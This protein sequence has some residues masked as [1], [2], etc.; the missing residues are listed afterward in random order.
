MMILFMQIQNSLFLLPWIIYAKRAMVTRKKKRKRSTR[1]Q[2]NIHNYAQS[3]LSFASVFFLSLSLYLPWLSTTD[4]YFFC[5]IFNICEKNQKKKDFFQSWS[6]DDNNVDEHL[7]C[8]KKN[9]VLSNLLYYSL[10][11]IDRSLFPDYNK[12]SSLSVGRHRNHISKKSFSFSLAFIQ[13]KSSE[14]GREDIIPKK[15]KRK[16]SLW[17]SC[18]NI[19]RTFF[20]MSSS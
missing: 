10:C 15:K 4:S 2:E 1:M 16:T 12:S 11:I 7:T 19:K 17:R 6:Y 18:R 14:C 5:Y 20:C 9:S 3:T 13:M 8:K